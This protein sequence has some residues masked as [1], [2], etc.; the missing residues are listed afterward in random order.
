[1]KIATRVIAV[2]LAA[3]GLLMFL[4]TSALV[5][6]C[7]SV[8]VDGAQAACIHADTTHALGLVLILAAGV[9]MVLSL[10]HRQA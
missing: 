4:N 10:I 5:S 6:E 2:I 1:M 7:H 3:I 8:W 9:T